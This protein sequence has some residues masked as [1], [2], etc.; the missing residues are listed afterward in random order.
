MPLALLCTILL[1]TLFSGLLLSAARFIMYLKYADKIALQKD[2]CDLKKAFFLG[3]RFDLKVTASF[4][5]LPLIYSLIVFCFP[6][7][8]F[9]VHQ[10]L[11]NNILLLYYFGVMLLFITLL[12]TDYFFYSYFNDRINYLI[13][14]LLDDDFKAL[15]ITVWK[16]YPVLIYL[17]LTFLGLTALFFSL[18]GIF[19]LADF[20]MANLVN[21]STLSE[22]MSAF[23]IFWSILLL[24]N[25]I[26]TRGTIRHQPLSIK[27]ACVSQ[28]A[29]INL[30]S[31][32]ALLLMYAVIKLRRRNQKMKPMVTPVG[33]DLKNIFSILKPE[34]KLKTPTL[35]N[36]FSKR[37]L[38]PPNTISTHQSH[39]IVFMMESFGSHFLME[40][41]EQRDALLGRLAPHF[42]E[43]HVFY[44]FM[45]EAN[46]TAESFAH[47]CA[48][49][50]FIPQSNA[51]T[52]S[53]Y[54]NETLPSSIASLY[55]KEGYKTSAYYG[56]KLAWR[57][58]GQFLK[59]QN[60]DEVIGEMEIIKTMALDPKCEIGNEWGLFDEY[61]FKCVFN[62]LKTATQP[63]LI[64]IL[65]TTNHP[66]YSTPK[67]F[68]DSNSHKIGE[69]FKSLF[70]RK[71]EAEK[72]FKTYEYSNSVLGDFI[73]QIKANPTLKAQTLIA[74][75]G[76]HAFRGYQVSD[77][78]LFLRHAVPFYLYAPE[79]Y[80]KHYGN[81][82]YHKY[83]S[84]KDIMP[85]LIELSLPN[86]A[87]LALGN[88][89]LSHPENG[90]GFNSDGVAIN[91]YGA[92]YLGM[93]TQP[94][95]YQWGQAQSN[96]TQYQTLPQP[97]N[98]SMKQLLNRY[99]ATIEATYLFL[100]ESFK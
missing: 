22:N 85:T 75:T 27:H 64:F 50:P 59:A 24:L 78:D 14:G 46:G 71:G 41:P 44:H 77:K 56:G 84:H 47:L 98:D 87:Y 79:A 2:H 70:V 40:Y 63:Q 9:E 97:E 94:C 45:S 3:I 72:R 66:P 37:G 49:L 89:M 31:H 28:N 13:W 96:H 43:D 69:Q 100:N 10:L 61:L 5:F 6:T 54:L 53:K 17:L 8:Y 32:N 18:Q 30:L 20:L 62:A 15:M 81:I 67:T 88:S 80:T 4:N 92:V 58:I 12:L 91:Q 38:A 57:N 48:N 23:W 86:T 42:K 60:F 82:D 68:N 16:D 83:G 25:I 1:F 99:Y 19:Y 11:I 76:D 55:K 51:L 39:V 95:H 29:F 73:A 34:Y 52:E 35:E 33:R 65:S 21:T 7:T 74:I 36:L 26:L 90:I 93:G